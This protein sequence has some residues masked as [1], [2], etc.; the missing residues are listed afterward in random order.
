VDIIAVIL[1]IALAISAAFTYQKFNESN[2]LTALQAAGF[3]PIK[4]SNPLLRM[5]ELTIGYLYVGNAYLSPWA[6]QEFRSFEF[7]I[8]NNVEPIEK[9]GTIFSNNGFSVYAQK[10]MGNFF[11]GNLY[12]I[13]ARN[14]EK[15]YNY[16]AKKGTIKNN[17]LSLIEGERIEIDFSNHKNSIM[18]FKSYNCDLKDI[19]KS[20]RK[21]VQP[22]EKFVDELLNE[23]GDEEAVKMSKALFH[24][25]M[26]SP[27]LTAIFG[28][29]A[30][31]LILMAPHSRKP[32]SWRMVLLTALI[33]IFQGSFF[34]IA[35]AA[36]RNLEFA[37]LNYILAIS[38]II[39]TA[40]LIAKNRGL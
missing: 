29:L 35:N 8:K 2:Q 36:T 33:L 18:R 27:L 37:K 16:F 19:I 21:A 15:T 1:P 22:N 38:S 6:W 34:W 20:E 4:V 30:F 10:Y 3:S 25:K 28:A 32:S 26:A 24:Q 13:D 14:P 7:E 12:V 23:N 5:I 39:A 11:L 40:A 9:S 17:A 31:L